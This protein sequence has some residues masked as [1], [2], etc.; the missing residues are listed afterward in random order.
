MINAV[1]KEQ[2]GD[3][4]IHCATV[5]GV[6]PGEKQACGGNGNDDDGD[7]DED[8]GASEGAEHLSQQAIM[9]SPV[10]L[11]KPAGNQATRCSNLF[12][13][14]DDEEFEKKCRALVG[15]N[16]KSSS[17]SAKA[18]PKSQPPTP[19][20]RKKLPLPDFK[21]IMDKAEVAPGNKK[22]QSP[23]AAPRRQTQAEK[24]R[25]S[26]SA[27]VPSSTSSRSLAI[28]IKTATKQQQP[29][30]PFL[31]GK[32]KSGAG[33]EELYEHTFVA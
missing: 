29:L 25:I 7:D 5:M 27:P 28:V 3:Q 11:K 22:S 17:A 4:W 30:K 21:M 16:V 15:A 18:P 1:L 32:K 8:D 12:G 19:N 23:A 6:P 31:F 2:D 9:D 13:S 20:R 24:R 26:S 14:D 33:G 10:V